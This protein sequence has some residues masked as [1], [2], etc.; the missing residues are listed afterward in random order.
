[1]NEVGWADWFKIR[2]CGSLHEKQPESIK[3]F[4]REA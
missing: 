3:G 1:M 2:K 4:S